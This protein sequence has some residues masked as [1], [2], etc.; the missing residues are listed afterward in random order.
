MSY[1][2]FLGNA[3]IEREFGAEFQEPLHVTVKFNVSPIEVLGINMTGFYKIGD[4][5]CELN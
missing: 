2:R 3:C 5:I 4:P 1:E